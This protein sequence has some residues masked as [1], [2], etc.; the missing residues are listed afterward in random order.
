MK[1]SDM[2]NKQTGQIL[3]AQHVMV[4]GPPKSGKTWLIG[5]LAAAG[6]Q[7]IWIDLENG[8]STLFQLPDEALEN[9]TYVGVADTKDEP[10]AHATVD[11]LCRGGIFNICDI[12]GRVDCPL[13]KKAGAGF[14]Q[15]DIPTEFTE[16]TAK[17]IVVF[18]SGTQL[19]NSVVATVTKGKPAD[20]QET[21]HDYRNAGNYLNRIFSYLQQA[22]FNFII[23]AH[24]IEAEREDGGIRIVPSIGTRAYAINC[25]KFFDHV[26]YMDK[27]NLKHK[28][29]SSTSF[30]N[31][32]LTGSRLNI[33][34]E[35]MPAGPDL[36]AI[37]EGKVMAS[38]E[39]DN[40]KAGGVLAGLQA[41]SQ[42]T[43]LN[44]ASIG[45]GTGGK[46]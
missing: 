2:K 6:Y 15:I 3:A 20:Y 29:S 44:L 32:I 8:K 42:A 16:A 27:V 37:F 24:E 45:A 30:S 33:A 13:C 36:A 14:T 17:T 9:I 4:Y 19:S 40:S 22:K 10:V 12:H 11:K 39:A 23:T 21:I 5:C 25:A 31:S 26:V 1:L 34:V 46:K 38:K 28:A 41:G 18:D 7:L 35:S 43:K